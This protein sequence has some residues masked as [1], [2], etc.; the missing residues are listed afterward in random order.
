VANLDTSIY[1]EELLE[2]RREGLQ[3]A[4]DF[5]K[6]IGATAYRLTF[7]DIPYAFDDFTSPPDKKLWKAHPRGGFCIREKVAKANKAKRDELDAAMRAIK[8]PGQRTLTTELTGDIFALHHGQHAYYLKVDDLADSNPSRFI[9]SY[10]VA[11]KTDPLPPKAQ[12]WGMVIKESRHHEL[13][14]IAEATTKK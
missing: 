4:R 10:P 7:E 6:S 5:A 14:E 11:S 8:V 12:D 9:I 3:K 2:R 13:L 1:L